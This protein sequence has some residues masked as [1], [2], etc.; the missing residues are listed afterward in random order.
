[1]A[2]AQEPVAPYTETRVRCLN[3]AVSG[4]TDI[5][6]S[7]DTRH[8]VTASID[9]GLFDARMLPNDGLEQLRRR[10]FTMAPFWVDGLHED[11][12]EFLWNPDPASRRRGEEGNQGAE[13]TEKAKRTQQAFYKAGAAWAKQQLGAKYVFAQ[14]H[15]CRYGNQGHTDGRAYLTSYATFA[16]CDYTTRI[17]DGEAGWRALVARGVAEEEAK[18]MHVGY[19]N[20]WQSTNG[21]VE[22]NPLALSDWSTTEEADAHGVELGHT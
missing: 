1:M 16:H 11:L 4:R 22:Q 3:P 14:S 5:V 12:N 6:Y 10:G 7:K 20:I 13:V 15:T 19:Y 18:R 21:T 2:T 17:T 9:V 8:E